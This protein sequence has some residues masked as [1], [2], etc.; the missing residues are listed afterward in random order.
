MV[1]HFSSN[2]KELQTLH[3]TMQQLEKE[4]REAV[5]GTTVFYFTDNSVTYWIITGGSSKH[6]PLHKLVE[7][8]RLIELRIQVHLEVVHV[9]GVVKI[10]QGTDAL[11]R[12]IWI[13]P[14]QGLSSSRHLTGSVFAPFPINPKV[15]GYYLDL[16]PTRHGHRSNWRYYDWQ[17]PLL[18]ADV[19]H[20]LT[21]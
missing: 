5:A 9:P 6:P 4:P 14:L 18:S 19:F 20:T 1:F 2:W 3:L 12:G 7:S 17:A 8:I 16:L 11:S 13:T 10:K 21:V 15:V